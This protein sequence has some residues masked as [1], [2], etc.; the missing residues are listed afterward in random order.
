[1]IRIVESE[2]SFQSER[3][4]E[5]TRLM[6]LES[7]YAFQ[8]D[9]FSENLTANATTLWSVVISIGNLSNG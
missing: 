8:T 6:Q 1:M 3:D 7:I 4:I 2:L 5:I 9:D